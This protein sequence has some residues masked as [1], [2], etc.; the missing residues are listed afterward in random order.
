M[1]KYCIFNNS[2]LCDNCNEC[3]ICELDRKKICDN[4]GKCLEIEGIDI[5]S[6][7]VEEVATNNDESEIYEGDLEAEFDQSVVGENDIYQDELD[8]DN[9]WE[10][11]DDIRDIKDIIEDE[12][13]FKDVAFEEFPGL[14]RLKG[15]EKEK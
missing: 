6:I 15:R 9:V 1:S 7:K 12:E 13:R 8:Q 11:I 10:Y 3:N 5:R 2:K 14:I 4:C